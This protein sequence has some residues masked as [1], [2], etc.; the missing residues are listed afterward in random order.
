MTLRDLAFVWV[1][2]NA[3][4]FFFSVGVIAFSLGPD[5]WQAL[6]AVF[7]GNALFGYVAWA[8]IAGVRSGLPTMTL[9][10][11]PF[12]IQGN[13]FNG[14]LA[15][16]TSVSFEALNTVFGVFA[17]AALLPMLGWTDADT[18]GKIIALVVVFFLSAAIAVLGHATLVYFQRIFA[19]LLTVVARGR[20][21]LHRG[22]RR[23]GRRPGG[24]AFDRRDDRGDDGRCGHR[25][26][27]PA[28]VPLQRLR[29]VALPA[30]PTPAK[31]IFWTVLFS[32]SA[33]AAVP[34]VSWA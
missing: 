9:T 27:G 13:R 2:T 31:S 20:V 33:I 3:Y 14:V 19:V 1:G 18:A 29:L 5:V 11:A 6:I 24:V 26:L 28:L 25:R 4:L 8:S 22:R 17:V 15:W 7:V 23:L 10:R 12:G 30:E 16:V 21:L 32:A 34:R